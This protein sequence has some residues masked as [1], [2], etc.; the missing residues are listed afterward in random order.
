MIENNPECDH[1][2][3]AIVVHTA[4]LHADVDQE[5]FAEPPEPVEWYESELCEDSVEIEESV[6]PLSQSTEI[7]APTRCKSLGKLKLSFC[8]VKS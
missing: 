3:I 1:I 8:Q 7:V 4:F 5:L 6:V 2:T